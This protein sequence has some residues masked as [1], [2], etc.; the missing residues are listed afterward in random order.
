M[1][2]KRSPLGQAGGGTEDTTTAGNRRPFDSTAGDDLRQAPSAQN[3][4]Y[5]KDGMVWCEGKHLCSIRDGVLSR[6][7]SAKTELLH[8]ALHFRTD[9][10]RLAEK[11]GC[12]ELLA[13]ERTCG[14]RYRVSLATFLR[15]ARPY[16]HADFGSQ[17]G[18]ALVLWQW[19]PSP[20]DMRQL[21]LWRQHE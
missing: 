9:V 6:T 12:V 2:R 4:V 20:G 1:S 16:T 17:L 13:T 14:T 18:L 21:A 8:G 10:M 3:P 19:L 5:V 7:F 15:R 11:A